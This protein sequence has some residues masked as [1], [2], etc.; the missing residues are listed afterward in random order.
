MPG[1]MQ[2]GRKRR[3]GEPS[4]YC[5]PLSVT[6]MPRAGGAS[7]TPRLLGS[8]I[9]VSGIL[10]RPLSRTMTAED[11]PTQFRHPAAP[12]ARVVH[13]VSP[14]KIRGRGECRVPDAPA[15]SRVEKN[16]RV[17]HH[18]STGITR[19]SLR[20]GFT[21]Y[22]VLSPAT[23]SFLSPS[24]TDMVLPDPV[25]LEK[26]PPTWHQQRMPGPH[27][28][29]VRFSAV[30]LRAVNRSQETRPAISSARRRCRVHRIPS[31]RS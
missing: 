18:R 30:R 16:T 1:S 12:S 28:F 22:I 11:M 21:A 2:R 4:A 26:P 27:G 14:W 10:D 5:P 24:S 19:H 13:E 17:S 29:A 31:Q 7:S 3:E 8:I 25:G 23:N 6:V 20:N 9:D 15:A